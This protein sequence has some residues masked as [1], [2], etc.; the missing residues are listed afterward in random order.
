RRAAVTMLAATIVSRAKDADVQHV[1]DTVA[2]R[3][4]PSWLRAS[5]LR[6]AEAQ[7]LGIDPITGRGRGAPAPAPDAPCPTCPGG[8]SGPGGAPAFATGR[9]GEGGRAA[10]PGGRGRGRGA[11]R[12]ALKLDREPALVGLAAANDE[13]STRAR[14]LLARLEWP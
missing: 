8:R 11:G 4:R 10:T 6:G 7:L 1:F 2:D 13:L 14:D 12:P 9:A 3:S 5:L